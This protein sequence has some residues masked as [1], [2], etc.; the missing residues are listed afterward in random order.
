[1]DAGTPGGH[2]LSSGFRSVDDELAALVYDSMADT[3]LLASVRSGGRHARQLTFEAPQV[4][5]EIEVSSGRRLVGQVVP[6][7]AAVVELR[8]R[9]GTTPV[10]TDELGCFHVREMPDGPVSFRCCPSGGEAHSVATSWIAL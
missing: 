2:E 6:P 3:E 9:S 1:V 8:H 5:L 4:T 10:A 7:Q